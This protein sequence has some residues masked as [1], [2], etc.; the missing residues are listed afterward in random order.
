MWIPLMVMAMH[1]GMICSQRMSGV[2]L[3]ECFMRLKWV[4]MNAEAKDWQ[5]LAS[6]LF[7]EAEQSP[8]LTRAFYIPFFSA[9]SNVYTGY[10]L[11]VRTSWQQALGLIRPPP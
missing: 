1:F 8:A 4:L 11:L 2:V 7:L 10:Q 3:R 6:R 5:L 9:K